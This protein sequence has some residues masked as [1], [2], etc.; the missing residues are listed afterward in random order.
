MTDKTKHIKNAA[1]IALIGNTILGCLKLAVGLFSGSAALVGDG[2]DS[3][4]DVLISIITLV[5]VG[6]NTALR[7][8]D[9]L[10]LKWNDV[11]DYVSRRFRSHITLKESKTGK[12]KKVRL[13][14][15]VMEALKLY[16][17]HKRGDFIFANNRK[18]MLPISRVQAFRI[19]KSAAKAIKMKERISC[20]SLRKTLGYHAW[21][22]GAAVAV[23]MD[24]Y[25]HTDYEV[26]RR[27]LGIAQ[28]DRDKIYIGMALV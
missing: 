21:R 1:I 13:N 28:D 8:S 27:Y 18:N 10:R 25:N 14:K 20:H 17:P 23:I 6:I 24:I 11:Y 9:L 7:I 15:Q 3:S 19:I 26:T 22:T 4:A 16:W 5:V 12:G 2:L